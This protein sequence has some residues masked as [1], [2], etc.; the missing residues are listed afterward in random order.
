M[1]IR[2]MLGLSLLVAC[3][4]TA[5]TGDTAPAASARESVDEFMQAVADSNLTK[6]AMLW[7]TANGPAAVTGKPADYERR[8]AVMHSFLR[9]AT[10][11]LANEYPGGAADDRRTVVVRV[12]RDGCSYDLPVTA[13][14]TASHGWL[15]NN[16][17][18]SVVGAPGRSCGQQIPDSL[19]S[20][21]G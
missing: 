4:G 9:G 12:S 15:V 3:G 19:P 1:N 6:M 21:E 8:V 20:P 14:R 5:R 13:V 17:D 11:A 18:L 2:W 16:F 7:G 10:F